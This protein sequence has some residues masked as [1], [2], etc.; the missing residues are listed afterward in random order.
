MIDLTAIIRP[1]VEEQIKAYLHAHPSNVVNHRKLVSGIGKRVTHD[2]CAPE[3][4]RRIELALR[5]AGCGCGARAKEPEV[6]HYPS[7][8]SVGGV[9]PPTSPEPGSSSSS[10]L[11]SDVGS[12][13]RWD[14]QDAR[15][16][17][18]APNVEA[19]AKNRPAGSVGALAGGSQVEDMR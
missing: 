9:N 14:R 1:I 7:V 18:A 15:S 5:G 12:R 8:A 17:R 13:L 2:I 3:T 6:S 4:V 16:G 11:S 10:G 19:V